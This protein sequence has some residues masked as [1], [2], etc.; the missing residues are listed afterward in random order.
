MTEGRPDWLDEPVD[1]FSY[2]P[3]PEREPEPGAAEV[4]PLRGRAKRRSAAQPN[5]N[6]AEYSE[7]TDSAVSERLVEEALRE[8]WLYT[9]A[10]GWLRW[11]GMVWKPQPDAVLIEAVRSWV[12]AEVVRVAA[13]GVP[14]R[15]RDAAGLQSASRIARLASLA[16]GQI[17][18]DAAEFDQ[19]PEIL[20]CGNGVANVRTG[21]VSPHDPSRLVTK[22]TG[23]D[24]RPGATHA[25]WD[26]ALRALPTDTHDWAQVRFGQAATGYQPDDDRMLILQ[27]GGENGKS[28]L[29]VG[30]QRALGDYAVLVPDQLLTGSTDSHPADLMT[31]RGARLAVIEETPEGRRLNVTRLKKVIGTP[32]ITARLMRQNFTTFGATH[33]LMLSTNFKLQVDETDHGTWRRLAMLRCP[34]TFVKPDEAQTGTHHRAGDPGLKA[35]LSDTSEQGRAQREAVLAWIVTGAM[36]WFESGRTMPS[37]PDRV[38]RDTQSWRAESDFVLSY[39]IERL[40]ADPSSRIW[41]ADLL[42]DFNSNLVGRGQREWSDRTLTER[43]GEHSW[44]SENR[45]AKARGRHAG[46]ALSRSPH[47]NAL[48]EPPAVHPAWVGVRFKPL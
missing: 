4:V 42:A 12:D 25:D 18:A 34:F 41:T 14:A 23:V 5:S 48:G 2:P 36:R 31:L 29:L 33:S 27:G 6:P 7:F 28:T 43:F 35:R 19:D 24:Y 46:T 39:A 17:I 1:D 37:L 16:R 45:V 3:E 10:L 15:T 8:R 22:S 38:A 20:V 21:L 32:E 40:E 9:D 26:S 47:E 11:T 30:I 44:A 13:L